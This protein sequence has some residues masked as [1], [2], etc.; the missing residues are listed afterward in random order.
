MSIVIVDVETTGLPGNRKYDYKDTKAFDS[1]RIVQLSYII[2]DFKD[3]Y[4]ERNYIIK[5]DDFSINNSHI[6]HITNEISDNKGISIMDALVLFIFD[7]DKCTTLYAH[8]LKFDLNV[9]KSEMYRI[10]MTFPAEIK[11]NC[12][13]I[14]DPYSGKFMK[15]TE[16]YFSTFNK[17][18]TQDHNAINDCKILYEILK[19]KL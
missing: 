12:T 13:M 17:P 10:G 16:L 8:N 6:H 4:H 9:I 7:I 2:T 11:C 18:I 14:K 15:L 1:A 5:R 3:Y 19:T